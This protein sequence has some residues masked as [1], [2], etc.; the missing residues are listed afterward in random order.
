VFEPIGM[1]GTTLDFDAALAVENHA[2]PHSYDIET[3]DL[4]PIATDFERFAIPV[5]PAGAVWS[6]VEDMARY[7]MTDLHH[8]VAPDGTRVVSE[9]NLA[10]TQSPEI[11]IGGR[12][13]YGMGWL[14]DEFHGQ[15]LIWHNGGTLGFSSDISFMPA[16]GLA[17]VVLTNRSAG[18][19]FNHAVRDYVFELA[20][21]LEHTADAR[22]LSAD[23]QLTALGEQMMSGIHFEAVD[24]DSVAIFLGEY[25]RGVQV[26]MNGDQFVAVT[27]YGEIPLYATDQSDVFIAGGAVA[28][29]HLVFTEDVSIITLTIG[30]PFDPSQ[31]I[32]LAKVG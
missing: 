16:A 7:L 31:D 13:S 9:E 8:G 1:T 19:N 22:Y 32:T 18:D 29:F 5:A 2:I 14:V 25:E 20:F 26:A 4:I 21:D 12:I 10:V 17:G 15:P 24:P 11:F 30:T 3:E 28:G 6:N 23:E 27:D